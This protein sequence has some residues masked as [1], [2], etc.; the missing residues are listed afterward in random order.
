MNLDELADR[1]YV[2]SYDPVSVQLKELLQKWKSDDS[3][4]HEL[5]RSVERFIGNAWIENAHEHNEIYSAW[6]E[7]R[8]NEIELIG[9][10]TMNE[11]LHSF[12][13]FERFESCADEEA[14][15]LLY[16]KHLASQ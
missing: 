12:G 6:T 9:G 3:T 7:F 2:L 1:L 13:L 14:Q 16:R 5:S 4:V 11:R 8:E 10:K 15:Q